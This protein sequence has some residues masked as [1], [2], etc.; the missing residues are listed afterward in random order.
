[1][2]ILLIDDSALFRF[3]LRELLIKEEG[4]EVIAEATNGLLGLEAA[5]KH[6]PD[7]IILDIDMPVM[8]GIEATKLIMEKTPCPIMILS[9]SVDSETSFKACQAGALDV[10]NKPDINDINSPKFTKYFFDKLRLLSDQK[11]EYK[12]NIKVKKS[13][14]ELNIKPQIVVIGA[15]TGGP[16]A[17]REIVSSLPKDFPLPIA[18]VQHLEDGFDHGFVK[19]LSQATA[20]EV[21]LVTDREQLVNSKI[22]VAPSNKHIIFDGDYIITSDSE[23]VLNQKPSVNVLFNSAATRFKQNVLGVLLTG[24]GRDG[25]SGCQDILN[26]GGKTIVQNKESSVIYGMPKEAVD[27]NAASVVVPLK[28]I[29]E[30]FLGV[31]RS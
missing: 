21:I 11:V 31:V 26:A 12:I 10:M 17:I 9:S 16:K 6:K 2:N 3:F 29:A 15:S 5:I 19:W 14:V 30:I 27:L 22:Y 4:L 20:L 1:M 25:G 18:I 28:N 8:N 23:K 7:L 24:M 13:S